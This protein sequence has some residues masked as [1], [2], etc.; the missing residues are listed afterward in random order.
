MI[1]I[2]IILAENQDVTDIEVAASTARTFKGE[3]DGVSGTF[4]CAANIL[5]DKVNPVPN[6]GG[7]L[8][9][10]GPLASWTFESDDYVESVAKQDAD[11]MYFGYWLQSPDPDPDATRS[12]VYIFN[13]LYGR[14]R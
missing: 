7:Q 1:P 9:V 4:T 6:L 10:S 2:P 3:S 5:C 14:R 13:T 11:Y 12:G 8:V